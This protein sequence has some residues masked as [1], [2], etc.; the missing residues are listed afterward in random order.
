M[1][2]DDRELEEGQKVR[3]GV[4]VKVGEQISVL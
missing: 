3:V 2:A 4:V 1:W